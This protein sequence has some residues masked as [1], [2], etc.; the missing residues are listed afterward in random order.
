M[1]QLSEIYHTKRYLQDALS[2]GVSTSPQDKSPRH[3][4]F[5]SPVDTSQDRHGNT[6]RE[7][8][9]FL[10][11]S[12]AQ[13]MGHILRGYVKERFHPTSQDSLPDYSLVLTTNRHTD[14][15]IIAH[16]GNEESVVIPVF[17]TDKHSL[18]NDVDEVLEGRLSP[19]LNTMI[20]I[21]GNETS[22]RLLH[23]PVLASK[24]SVDLAFIINRMSYRGI[25]LARP[26]PYIWH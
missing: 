20:H 13:N 12:H 22:D 6:T 11:W 26:K 8:W 24:F 19:E 4:L 25:S 21:F 2:I 10:N 17:G 3:G 7:I 1:G 5:I 15:A 23:D 18:Q 14:G 9:R 16:I